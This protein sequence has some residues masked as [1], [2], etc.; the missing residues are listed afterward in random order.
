MKNIVVIAAVS[1]PQCGI[2][3]DGKIPWRLAED[4]RHFKDTTMRVNDPTK[5]NAVLMGRSTWESLPRAH[6]PLVGRRNVVLSASATYRQQ[7]EADMNALNGEP[8]KIIAQ[9]TAAINS[10]QANPTV[11]T[12]FIIGGED[13]Y[14]QVLQQRLATSIVI[15]EVHYTGDFDT[16]F[17]EIPADYQRT[18]ES[19][20]YE[21]KGIKYRYVTYEIA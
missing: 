21:E 3:Y 1:V 2:G 5:K 7:F 18:N 19:D 14:T 12:I 6:R 17:P 8:A 20:Y 4:M 10:L 15:T 9:L 13:V 16:H 11:E